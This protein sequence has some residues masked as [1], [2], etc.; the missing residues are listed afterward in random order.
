MTIDKVENAKHFPLYY[1]ILLKNK[2]DTTI[3]SFDNMTK[4]LKEN[5]INIEM[6]NGIVDEDCNGYNVFQ[7]Y[8]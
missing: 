4:Y 5:L 2:T 8:G 6:V 1:Y 7:N 3:E